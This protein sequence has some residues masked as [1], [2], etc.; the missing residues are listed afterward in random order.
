M[1]CPVR[2]VSVAAARIVPSYAAIYLLHFRDPP[3]FSEPSATNIGAGGKVASSTR[4]PRYSQSCARIGS[5]GPL[6]SYHC[7]TWSC[8]L[9]TTD[10]EV[11][12]TIFQQFLLHIHHQLY[13]FYTYHHVPYIIRWAR[14]ANTY[15]LCILQIVR[16]WF[17]RSVQKAD[18]SGRIKKYVWR[19]VLFA[20]FDLIGP[21]ISLCLGLEVGDPCDKFQTM[22][23][24]TAVKLG[25][26][27]R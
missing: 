26:M 17:N 12:W 16:K 18:G 15:T 20:R 1:K 10:R 6:H 19:W 2:F 21:W 3:F 22:M 24:Y 23:L 9:N 7:E 5:E 13:I 14:L 25:L 11:Y 8:V 27:L 4:S